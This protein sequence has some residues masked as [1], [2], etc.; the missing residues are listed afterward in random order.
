MSGI[1]VNQRTVERFRFINSVNVTGFSSSTSFSL[2]NY[3]VFSRTRD[4]SKFC[5]TIFISS[6]TGYSISSF[7]KSSFLKTLHIC[8]HRILGAY[9]LFFLYI[10]ILYISIY[11]KIGNKIYV[12]YIILNTKRYCSL[13]VKM[14][15][16]YMYI[17]I[18]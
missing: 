16:Y 4:N 10:S 5:S 3:F 2:I 15:N 14:L 11:N 7:I 1:K 12:K 6:T 18:N 17:H 9:L 8:S 13:N